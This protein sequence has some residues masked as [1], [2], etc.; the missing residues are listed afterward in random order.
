[1][2]KNEPPAV[3]F[4]KIAGDR[5]CAYC[6]NNPV[7]H[8]LTWYFESTSALLTPLRRFLLYSPISK[9]AFKFFA[10]FNPALLITR[11]CFALGIVSFQDRAGQCKVRRAQ[12]L[13]EEAGKRGIEMREL[14]VF[15]KSVDT[16]VAAKT[17]IPNSKPEILNLKSAIVF[18]GL[19]R[20]KNYWNVNFEVL[21][22]KA[23]L[24][25]FLAKHRLPAPKGGMAGNFR[26]AKRIFNQILKP[27]IVKPRAGS[28]GR[29]TTTFVSSVDD[30]T[31]AFKAAKQLCFW[32]VVEEQ[33]LGPVYRA[34]LINFELCGALRGDP[35]QIV[36]DGRHTIGEL[37]NSKNSRPRPG[38]KDII[39]DRS[40]EL[41][42]ERELEYKFEIPVSL[43]GRRN[44]KSETN[45]LPTADL[46]D[47]FQMT[48]SKQDQAASIFDFI[49]QTGQLVDLSEKIGVSYGGSSSEDF[50]IC[51]EDNKQLFITAAKILGDPIVG[52]DFIIPDITASWKNQR[53]GFIEANSLPFINLH[54]DPLHGQPRNVAA[55]VWD[56]A[57]F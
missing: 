35:P 23:L 15:G 55:K 8:L 39:V 19:P 51:H 47:K 5:P 56:L 16:Y 33:L 53:C 43:A 17:K 44:P 25:K 20:P 31:T 57:G 18:S 38:V 4:K 1:M 41:F 11:L 14:K 2:G 30:L 52:F 46:Y 24:K 7:P 42:V 50:D 3:F 54:H 28:R 40:M 6:G 45:S 48:N 37:I 36:G 9:L 22:D 49:P 26:Q 12:V 21:D 29:H 10:R 13:W 34:T 32:A 27:V